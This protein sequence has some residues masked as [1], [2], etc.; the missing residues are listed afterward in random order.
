MQKVVGP[1]INCLP[2]TPADL[3]TVIAELTKLVKAYS[4]SISEPLSHVRLVVCG[5]DGSV[6]WVVCELQ[7]ASLAGVVPIA[8][9]PV[10]TG[11]DLSNFMGWA[12]TT[13]G[14]LGECCLVRVALCFTLCQFP[15]H[16]S[17]VPAR[18]HSRPLSY[19]SACSTSVT[20]M[21]TVL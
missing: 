11:N 4:A 19:M 12:P 1:A 13:M 17:F 8:V 18:C 2:L 15:P 16:A 14:L 6:A 21:H 5:G 20:I 3:M 10:G 7:R 9:I